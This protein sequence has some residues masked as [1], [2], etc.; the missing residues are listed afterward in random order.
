MFNI[1]FCIVPF[2]IHFFITRL[3]HI[4]KNFNKFDPFSLFIAFK[5]CLVSTFFYNEAFA[6]RLIFFVLFT[7]INLI[8]F[9]ELFNFYKIDKTYEIKLIIIFC[10]ITL[11]MLWLPGGFAPPFF[12]GIS[13][14]TIKYKNFQREIRY[15][16]GMKLIRN[17]DASV[18]MPYGVLSPINFVGR[19]YVTYKKKYPE[20]MD[21]L[22]KFYYSSYCYNFKILEKGFFPNQRYLKKF[23]YPGHNPSVMQDFK[24]FSPETIKS[25]SWVRE[26]IRLK[27]KKVLSRYVID[28]FTIP[29]EFRKINCGL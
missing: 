24:G 27:D 3:D 18:W 29:K 23:A 14:W 8:L 9:R 25:I 15:V 20:Y 13:G 10:K 2:C 26:K 21:D 12:S 28:E 22:Y 7:P 16:Y 4:L 19:H 11:I 6:K 17:D 5:L 1:I